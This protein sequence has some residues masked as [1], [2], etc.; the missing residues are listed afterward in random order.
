MG[1]GVD[2]MPAPWGEARG[3]KDLRVHGRRPP[4]STRD[5]TFVSLGRFLAVEEYCQA[6]QPSPTRPLRGSG[7]DRTDHANQAGTRSGSRA[8]ARPHRA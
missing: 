4:M 3:V 5:F 8:P 7:A 6:H 2:D 1:A